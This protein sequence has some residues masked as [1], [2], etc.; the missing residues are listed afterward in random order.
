MINTAP[1]QCLTRYCLLYCDTSGNALLKYVVV[2]LPC[3][4]RLFVVCACLGLNIKFAIH[5]IQMVTSLMHCHV[6]KTD[7]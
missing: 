2:Y 1:K 4:K 7:F 3:I 5:I 6:F